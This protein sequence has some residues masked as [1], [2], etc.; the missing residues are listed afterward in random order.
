MHMDVAPERHFPSPSPIPRSFLPP[1]KVRKNVLSKK[2][3]RGSKKMELAFS[4]LEQHSRQETLCQA[5]CNR[6]HFQPHPATEAG[7]LFRFQIAETEALMGQITCVRS[8][9]KPSICNLISLT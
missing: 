1:G 9:N 7:E 4:E 2:T 6:D 8:Q 5:L 3:G